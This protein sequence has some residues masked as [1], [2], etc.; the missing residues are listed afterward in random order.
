MGAHAYEISSRSNRREKA[1]EALEVMGI[2]VFS[3]MLTSLLA[4]LA[5]LMCT[6]Q[7][8][9]KFGFFLIFTVF[10]AWLWG[11]FFFMSLMF[12]LGPDESMPWWLRIPGSIFT[13]RADFPEDKTPAAA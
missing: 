11:N 8:F 3:G 7:F 12:L 5:L 2:S 10:W 13:R 6:L 9:A 1:H 4:S